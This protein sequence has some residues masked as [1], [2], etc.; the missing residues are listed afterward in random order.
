MNEKSL[1]KFS[2]CK[3][4]DKGFVYNEE[5]V[6]WDESGSGYSTKLI[7]CPHCGY[8]HVLGYIEDMALFT[9]VDKRYF[10]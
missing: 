9:N 8:Y 6:I 2:I 7:K 5:D 4:C 1:K 10:Y 3:K